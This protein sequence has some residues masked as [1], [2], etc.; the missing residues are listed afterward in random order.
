VNRVSVYLHHSYMNAPLRGESPFP[1][2]LSHMPITELKKLTFLLK[3]Q[4]RDLAAL[5][6]RHN[7]DA[8][9]IA[10]NER[11]ITQ[12]KVKIARLTS[13]PAPHLRESL[14]LL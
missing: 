3:F 1:E 10:L 13:G 6:R 5:R 14:G 2:D 9:A 7:P 12:L 11:A 8:D 4:E